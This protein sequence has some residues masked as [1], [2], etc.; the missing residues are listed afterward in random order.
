MAEQKTGEVAFLGFP[1]AA[2]YV[3]VS[4]G[5]LRRLVQAGRLRIYR[6]TPKRSVLSRTDLD[7]FM[8][9]CAATAR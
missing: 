9:S 3:G 5:S 4:V 8:E 2:T 6:P 7:A 1:D